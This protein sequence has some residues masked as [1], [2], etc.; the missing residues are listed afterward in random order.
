MN[1][2]SVIKSRISILDVT[3]EY[4]ALKKAGNYWKGQCPFH[5]EKT[6]SFT[7]SPHK[8]IFYCFG[9]H[10][11]GD[12]ITFIAQ[13]EQCSPLEAARH[14]AE[15]YGIPVSFENEEQFSQKHQ[16]KKD[17]HELC[18]LIAQWCHAQLLKS[19]L[20]MAYLQDRG[21]TLKLIQNF[22]LGYFPGGLASVNQFIKDMG[23]HRIMPDDLLQAHVL[24]K[25]KQ[26]L[27]SSFEERII[28]PISD[29]LG[30]HCGFGGRIFKQGDTRAKYYNSRENEYFTKGSLLFGL[31]RAKKAIQQAESVFLVEGYTDCIAMAQAGYSNTVA[32]LGTACTSSHLDTLGRYAQRLFIIYDNDNAG[33]QAMIR[34]AELAWQASLELSVICLPKGE[35]PAS[36]LQ[37][38]G[39]LTELI[40]NAPD[41]FT[42]FLQHLGSDFNAK[43]LQEKLVLIRRIVD[44]IAKIDDPLKKD[45]LLGQAAQ[46]IGVPLD[47]LKSELKRQSAREAEVKTSRP[48]QVVTRQKNPIGAELP[49]LE[50]KIFFAIMSNIQIFN[51]N[52]EKYLI[53]Y[54][55]QPLCDILK[56][57]KVAK[58]THETITFATFFDVLNEDEKHYVSNLLLAGD[59]TIQE[60]SF[61]HLM[62]ELKRKHWKVIVRDIQTKLELARKQALDN[63]VK[64]ILQDFL[65]LKK[66]IFEKNI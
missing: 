52:N 12:I 20:A 31:D 48:E 41:I 54:L 55:P 66:E 24:A 11:G 32:T 40:A 44:I 43:P 36:F 50:K 30:R 59:E 5:S 39:N 33:N 3:R 61:D 56:K 47:S 4:A 53:N 29:H 16:Q 46:M 38:K 18:K 17:Y 21:I 64:N 7:V 13:I 26:I 10:A 27:F 49:N 23:K 19:P 63:E 65:D 6:A 15:R 51:N 1:I 22:G 25:G 34:I 28:F 37:K 8:E 9:C 35:D 2:F 42:F 45:L 62:T 58:N 14:L 60:T 57:L